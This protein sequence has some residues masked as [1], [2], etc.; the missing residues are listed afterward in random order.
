MR[1]TYRILLGCIVP[2]LSL[3][4]ATGEH[5]Q[6]WEHISGRY[7]AIKGI[8]RLYSPENMPKILIFADDPEF[9]PLFNLIRL[10]T[11]K[12][13][14]VQN[15][16]MPSAV[17]RVGGPLRPQGWETN[18]PTDYPNPDFIPNSS[19]V[20]FIYGYSR[21]DWPRTPKAVNA[22]I[23]PVCQLQDLDNGIIE[24]REFQ[25]F[26]VSTLLIG[27]LSVIV[28]ILDVVNGIAIGRKS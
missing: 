2:I 10:K 20:V 17:T 23:V 15:S 14:D 3:I 1:K 19:P 7:L 11:S 25:R 16:N 18:L 4:Y 12:Q 26:W 6:W 5:L 8:E 9:R 27:I 21:K 28:V 24:S 22:R 13:I